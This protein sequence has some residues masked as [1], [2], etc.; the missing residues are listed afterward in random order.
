MDKKFIDWLLFCILSIIWGSSFILMK[1]GMTKL[2]PYQVAS[3]RMLSAGLVLL[4]FAFKALKKIPKVKMGLVFISGLIGSFIPAY[5]FCIA[6]TKIDSSLAG[7][8]NSLT[9][10]FTISVGLLFFKI[11]ANTQKLIGVAVGFIGLCL[12]F[13]AGKNISF[14]N[15]SYASLILIATFFYGLNVNM[16][17]KFLQNCRS[18]DIVST[19]FAFLIL[20][21]ALFLYSTGYFNLNFEDQNTIHASLASVC[22]G[23]MG[24]SIASILFYMLIKRS[25]VV[26]ASMVT[27]GI[28]IVAVAWGMYYGETISLVQVGSLLI[29]LAG[30]YIVNKPR[31]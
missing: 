5:L 9:P 15:L 4:P 21:S 3:I 17:G 26:F 2:S 7:I 11:Q 25:T 30:V 31:S 22:L 24:T 27:Y 14:E 10:L 29:I 13:T 18:I 28:P 23:V 19:A 12:L 16:V 20:P 1:E 8:L 6:E